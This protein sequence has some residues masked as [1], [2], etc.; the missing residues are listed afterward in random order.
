M[1]IEFNLNSCYNIIKVFLQSKIGDK[2]Y[3][4][5]KPFIKWAGGKS[6]L[7]NEIRKKYPKKI[8]RYCEPFVGGGAVLFDILANFT[9][10]EVLINDI[11]P[12]LINTYKQIQSHPNELISVL[13]ELQNKYWNANEIQ[14]KDLYSEKRKLFNE[15]KNNSNSETNIKRA[16]LFIFLNKTCFN[17]L[18]RVNSKGLFNVPIGAYKKPLI[19]NSENLKLISSLLQNVQIN[20]G[21]YTNCCKFIDNNTFVYIDPPYRPLTET[22]SFTSYTSNKFNDDEQISLSNFINEITIK[23]A[24]VVASNS[25]PK[26]IDENDEF[27]DKL[28]EKFNIQ[29]VFASRNINSKANL[30]GCISELLISND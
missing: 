1:Y 26:N 27:F 18:Y 17:G 11:N 5:V 29:R 9:P 10:E 2:M 12:E 8:N 22:A 24:K 15:Y 20:C 14:R 23:G 16:S 3:K 6:Q 4:T 30:R 7:L 28:Y 25:D 19:C 21:N 13:S